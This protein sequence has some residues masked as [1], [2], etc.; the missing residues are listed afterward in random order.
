[1]EQVVLS[2]VEWLTWDETQRRYFYFRLQKQIWPFLMLSAGNTLNTYR[3]TN[4]E[5]DLFSR[6][7]QAEAQVRFHPSWNLSARIE[8]NRNRDY[9]EVTRAFASL[10]ASFAA[11]GR[12]E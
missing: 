8:R 2:G 12:G 7:L 5:G 9:R 10:R 11:E 4:A 6:S 3:F 1:M